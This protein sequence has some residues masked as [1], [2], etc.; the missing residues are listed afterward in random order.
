MA[1]CIVCE[2]T[3]QNQNGYAIVTFQLPSQ[4]ITEFD[5]FLFNFDRLLNY[6]KQFRPSF[7]I[8]LGDFNATSKSWWPEDCY[9][10]GT[11][12]Y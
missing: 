2:I 11:H 7:T 4:S 5:K 6:I 1:Q 12:T 9:I 8:I 3:L 10:S